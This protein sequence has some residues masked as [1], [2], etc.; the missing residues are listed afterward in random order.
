MEPLINGL[1]NSK[2]N[3]MKNIYDY[4]GKTYAVECSSREEWQQIMDLAPD[5]LTT[6]INFYNE[7]NSKIIDLK[8]FGDF[9]SKFTKG[10]IIW[11]GYTVLPASDFLK[12]EFQKGNYI[13]TLKGYFKNSSCAKEN[14]CFKIRENCHYLRP[15]I[16]L[17]GSISNGNSNFTFSKISDLKEWRYATEEEIAEYERIGKPYDVTTLY[18]QPNFVVGKWYKFLWTFFNKEVI[19]KVKSI[20][21]AAVSTSFRVYLDT[22]DI[23]SDYEDGYCLKK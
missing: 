20:T 23:N 8:N 21:D 13:V 22:K 18:K 19:I 14:Y 6:K 7:S 11:T 2:R 9:W 12:Q 3:K 1:N 16:D 5:K 4:I 10:E 15:E 17:N